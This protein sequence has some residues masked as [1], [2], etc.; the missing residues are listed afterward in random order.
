MVGVL[1]QLLYWVQE[2]SGVYV[3]SVHL[4]FSRSRHT[5]NIT[6]ST[7]QNIKSISSL[8]SVP[9]FLSVSGVLSPLCVRFVGWRWVLLHYILVALFRIYIGIYI[10]LR[11]II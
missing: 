7:L 6:D 8:V 2:A 1:T 3:P 9:N 10:T 4:F 11:P 5:T